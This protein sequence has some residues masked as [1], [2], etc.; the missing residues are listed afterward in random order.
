[1]YMQ[2]HAG[3]LPHSFTLLYVRMYITSVLFLVISH[4]SISHVIDTK[5]KQPSC[6]KCKANQKPQWL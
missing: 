1:M 3:N 6:K 4:V 5:Q 2:K